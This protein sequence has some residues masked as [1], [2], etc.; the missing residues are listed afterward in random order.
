M[1]EAP[2]RLAAVE[3]RYRTE[4]GEL[5]V[6]LGADLTIAAGEI[7]ALV[8]PSGTGK[9]T[10]LH[11]AGLLEKPDGGEVFIAGQAAGSLSD[12]AR[13]TI[14]R[15]TIG[16]VYQFHH[17]LPE[18][19]AAENIILPQLA[20]GKSRAEAT[21]RAKDLLGVFGLQARLD[22]RPGKLSGGEQQRVAIA[23]ALANQPRLLL[24]DEPTGNLDVGTSDRVFAELLEQV[25]GQGLAALIA[26]HNPDLA[27]RMD[28]VVTLRDGKIVGA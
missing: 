1:N 5:P 11:L 13:T 27:R 2:L 18:F 25:R 15:T 10:L 28:R 8:A 23:R 19:T 4:A 17:L 20:A 22:H 7:V 21:E 12:E 3:R 26:T 24:A 6:L 16:F 14:R 9:S